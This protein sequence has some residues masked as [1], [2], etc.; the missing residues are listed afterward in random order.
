M[1]HI[2]KDVQL[3]E[4][5]EA[6]HKI[7]SPKEWFKKAVQ[8]NILEMI[9]QLVI[10]C[11]AIYSVGVANRWWWAQQVR[12]G[13]FVIYYFAGQGQFI[14]GWIYKDWIAPVFS[15]LNLWNP[16]DSYMYWCGFQTCCF[17]ILSHKLMEVKY[18]WFFVIISLKAFHDLLQVGN[19]QIALC[20]AAIY[21][22]TALLVILVKPHYAIFAFVMAITGRYKVW[23]ESRHGINKR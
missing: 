1:T 6:K 2:D 19:I 23:N 4:E 18:G 15:I 11:I 7:I 16:S 17:M 5:W 12:P 21:P 14:Q 10:V 8:F 22:I 13:D 3:I 20:L 9:I